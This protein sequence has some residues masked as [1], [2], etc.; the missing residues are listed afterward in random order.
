MRPIQT[1]HVSPRLP[2]ALE[3]LRPLAR[4]LRWAWDHATIELFRRLDSD[5][6]ESTGHNPVLMLG[7]TDQEQLESAARDEAFL[8]Q[9]DL[10]THELAGYLSTSA[11]WYKRTYSPVDG[12]LVAYFSAEFGL[13]EC[14]SIFA[15]GLGMLAGDHLKSASDLGLPLVGVGLLYQQGY[16]SQYLDAAGWQQESYRDN[17]FDNLP[18]SRE[19]QADGSPLAIEVA[20]P[21][22][23]VTAQVWRARV[24]RVSLYLLDTNLPA[25]RPED[26]DIT[27]QLYGGDREMRLKQEI[28]LGIGGFRAL[29]ALRIEPTVCHMNEGHSA[30]LSLERVRRLMEKHGLTFAEAREAAS[31]GLIFTTHTPVAAGHDYFP[32][33]LMDRYFGDYR[34]RLRLSREDFLALGRQ[35]PGN[36][37]E[38]FCMTVLALR[39]A[40]ASNGVSDLH[41]KV[42]R[43]M[44][45]NLWPG[46]PEDEIPIGHVTNGVHFRSWISMEMNQ[47]YDRYLGPKWREEHGDP[48]IWQR[49]ETIPG[50]ELWR[51]HERRRLRMVTYARRQL[52]A[53][54]Q[55]RGASRSEID[56]AADVL[57]PDALTIGF[58]RRF[59]TYKRATLLLRDAERLERLLS[60]PARP[61]QIVFAGKAHP[62]D[63]AGKQ[64]IQQVVRFARN[65]QFRRRMV[66]LEDYD[67]AV[68][69]YLVQGADVWLNTPLRP[70][71]ASGT[72][73]MK[74][75]ANG[76][77]NLST[78]DGWWD[79]AWRAATS[80]NYFIGWAIGRGET[81][82][83]HEYQ[84]Q[85]ESAALYD[86]LERDIVPAFYERSADGM[87]RRWI[88][89]MKSSIAHLCPVF[90]MQRVVREYASDF[91]MT[92][93]ERHASLSA[94]GMARGRALA[95]WVSRMRGAWSQ[96]RVESVEALREGELAVGGSIRV[97][98]WIRLGT[99]TPDEVAVELYMGRVSA[100]GDITDAVAAPM[101][102]S[103]P[104][105]DG[106][107]LVFETAD[108]A[109]GKSGLH[110]YTVRV[111]PFHR[112]EPSGFIPG[113]IAWAD[114]SVLR[115]NA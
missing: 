109:V 17:D 79:E 84:D 87:P 73:G 7:A 78:L 36:D 8:A 99:L 19:R 103:A 74:A 107:P 112:D 104:G 10:V 76:A 81:Y 56:A 16:F 39:M 3:P 58:A 54:L 64:F 102:L 61:V 21:G 65:K 98:A 37:S 33:P 2:P 57:N 32:P 63:D 41:G 35:N 42:T 85:V 82:E 86:L 52:H 106:G 27:D 31:A 59:A 108:V 60:D 113:L 83:D 95:G 44:W 48:R 22:R 93:H 72:S 96:V 23:T 46:V 24:G 49:V 40:A 70:Q 62:R 6:W 9:L 55:H 89:G 110:G 11:T 75:L 5:L 88:D 14:L 91:Y 12:L 71:E 114:S 25:N 53:Q 13:T 68:A 20:Y 90:N 18:L 29:E 67:M 1:F 105:G 15:G 45:K 4:N 94:D 66:F 100:A 43:K 77:L 111:L 51:T 38:E 101:S 115:A 92:A 47:L 97:K 34:A 50:A 80:A 26:R 30:F 69:R 28:L